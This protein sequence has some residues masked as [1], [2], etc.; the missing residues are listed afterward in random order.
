MGFDIVE[1]GTMGES[2]DIGFRMSLLL[3]GIH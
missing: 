3:C 1:M 2:L